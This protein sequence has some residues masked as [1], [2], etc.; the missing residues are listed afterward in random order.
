MVK[1]SRDIMKDDFFIVAINTTTS[2]HHNTG[3]YE[4]SVVNFDKE[5]YTIWVDPTMNNF[6]KWREVINKVK[7]GHG[8]LI[9]NCHAL[10]DKHTNTIVPNRINADYKPLISEERE[11]YFEMFD[12]INDV[13]KI[14][15]KRAIWRRLMKEVR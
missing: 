14:D 4:I 13:I 3:I 11:D 5:E 10:R 8:L 2:Q 12:A 7:A 6:T 1:K 9:K 15:P